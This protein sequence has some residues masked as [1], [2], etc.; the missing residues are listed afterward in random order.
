MRGFTLVAMVVPGLRRKGCGSDD[1]V[2]PVPELGSRVA[3]CGWFNRLK[4]S[5]RICRVLFSV[6]L[7][8]L[9]QRDV[10]V[11]LA[12]SQK[13]AQSGTAKQRGAG[14]T[15]GLGGYCHSVR[16]DGR[17]SAE[18]IDV[19]VAR[20]AAV[21]SQAGFDAAGGCDIARTSFRGTVARGRI[22]KWFRCRWSRK[23][24]RRRHP[25]RSWAR[26]PEW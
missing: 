12:R 3:N 13:N 1:N 7:R 4:N 15:G 24:C 20:T 10:K 9:D 18:G 26:H 16:H 21:S 2:P 5:P 25:R 19:E 8:G 22:R 17:R 23:P 11:E 6:I 14:G